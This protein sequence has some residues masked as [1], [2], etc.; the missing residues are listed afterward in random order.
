MMTNHEGVPNA[1]RGL[2]SRRK[3]SRPRRR[4]VRSP[5]PSPPRIWDDGDE[6]G[7]GTLLKLRARGG[8]GSG[9][10]TSLPVIAR[11]AS[12]PNFSGRRTT[13]A[14]ARRRRVADPKIPALCVIFGAGKQTLSANKSSA[15]DV[16]LAAQ[17]PCSPREKNNG[18]GSVG[19]Y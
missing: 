5:S 13:A 1:A 8:R 16:N 14:G 17:G 7:P 12:L 4:G 3:T 19:C 9:P 2:V 18:P 6:G 10:H 11:G 15:V